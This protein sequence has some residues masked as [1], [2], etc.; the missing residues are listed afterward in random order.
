[1]RIKRT[2]WTLRIFEGISHNFFDTQRNI[3]LTAKPE[4]IHQRLSNNTGAVATRGLCQLGNAWQHRGSQVICHAGVTQAAHCPDLRQRKDRL[5]L[6][7]CAL[8]YEPLL[9]RLS[10]LWKFQWRGSKA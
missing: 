4:M 9:L 1:M 7:A 10:T 8:L 3:S 6:P 2:A 5:L